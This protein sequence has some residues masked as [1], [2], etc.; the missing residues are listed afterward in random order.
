MKK[1]YHEIGWMASKKVA[2]PSRHYLAEIVHG[3]GRHYFLKKVNA[4]DR[5]IF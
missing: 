2:V 4:Q 3:P 1:T 5:H